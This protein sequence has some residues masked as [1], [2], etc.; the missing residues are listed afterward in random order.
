MKA[1]KEMIGIMDFAKNAWYIV[2][3]ADFYDR[4]N[5]NIEQI[6]IYNNKTKEIY[7]IHN[8]YSFLYSLSSE[9]MPSR[10]YWTGSTIINEGGVEDIKHAISWTLPQRFFLWSW[11]W[12]IFYKDLDHYLEKSYFNHI[13]Y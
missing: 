5:R 9:Y 10:G 1:T 6:H 4:D 12:P 11:K 8:H 3:Y 2:F 7:S 13:I